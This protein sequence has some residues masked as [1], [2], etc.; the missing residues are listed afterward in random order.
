MS[1][2]KLILVLGGTR[3]GK[4]YFAERM[5]ESLGERVVYLATAA[6]LDE[7]MALRVVNHRQRRPDKWQTREESI[8]VVDQVEGLSGDFD[9]ILLDCLT[10]WLTNL[11]LDDT[12][13]GP[14]K[15]IY[16]VNQVEQLARTCV[17]SKAH[18][19][20]VSNEVGHGLVPDNSLGRA[21]RDLSGQANQIIAKNADEVYWVVAGLPLEIKSRA[22]PF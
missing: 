20:I 13:S 19:I 4:S 6:V 18:V 7:E 17:H 15:E 1:K 21:F 22:Y 14:E 5:A 16:I 2:G 8:R 11:L 3:S 12:F 9:V 10:L